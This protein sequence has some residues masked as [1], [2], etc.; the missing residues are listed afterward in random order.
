MAFIHQGSYACSS[1]QLDL[2]TTPMTQT[3]IES[4]SWAEFN[5][6]SA[7][8]DS[9]PIEFDIS[10]AGMSYIDLSQTQLV[11]RAQLLKANGTPIDNTTHVAPCNLFLHSMFSEIDLKL[12]GTLITSSNNTYP[13]RAYIETLLSYGRDAKRSQL[14]SSLY[15]KDEGGDTGFEEGDPHAA[16]A[17][18]KGMVKRNS[19]FKTGAIVPMQ[20]PIHLDLLFQDRYLPSDVGAQLRLVRSKDAF[21]LMS[22]TANAAFRIKI[23]ECKLL[24]RKV[25]ISSS[26][27]VAQA[28]AFQVGNAKY[29]IRRV[30]CKSYSVGTGMRDNIHEGLFTGQ[31]PSRIVIAMVDNQAFNGSYEC[32]PFNFKHFDLSSIK[33]YVDGQPHNNIKAID[34]DFE[35]HQSLQGYLS[36]FA[37][38]GKYRKDE[39]LDLDREEYER[40]FTLFAYDLS[41]DLTEDGYFNLI[42]EGSIRVELKFA[43]ALPN[44]INVIAYAE[45][46]SIIEINREKQVL[47][48]YAN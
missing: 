12:N 11:V 39:G 3:S 14:T 48:D 4:G 8:S 5:P 2:F 21:S 43:Q 30:V 7:L 1:P 34:C 13:Y 25:N 22:D 15:Y 28:S 18:N 23:H 27:F 10:G 41:P 44:T 33:I 40:G 32:N 6:T 47:I 24:I 36:L 26:V 42:K 31:I 9:M 35:N 17:T 20:G 16:G 38:S 29:P 37:G 45:F 46:E 19:F